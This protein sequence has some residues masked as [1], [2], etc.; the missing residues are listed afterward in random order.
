MWLARTPAKPKCLAEIL[1][2]DQRVHYKRARVAGL[3]GFP[4]TPREGALSAVHSRANEKEDFANHENYAKSDTSSL[5]HF[6]LVHPLLTKGLLAASCVLNVTAIRSV[7]YE[8][9]A[10]TS[11]ELAQSLD[12]VVSDYVEYGNPEADCNGLQ[13]KLE[14]AS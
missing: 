3:Q 5:D 14:A 11:Y 1:R 12:T 8:Q 2:L 6:Y 10:S 4:S 13:E 7:E 9:N